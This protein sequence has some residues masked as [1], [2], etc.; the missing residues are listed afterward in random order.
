MQESEIDHPL[1]TEDLSELFEHLL[2]P[3]STLCIFK[4]LKINDPTFF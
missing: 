3:T 4:S 2:D 1:S